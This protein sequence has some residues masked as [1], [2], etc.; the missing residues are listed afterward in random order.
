MMKE[1]TEGLL[2]LRLLQDTKCKLT[3]TMHLDIDD[4]HQE[5]SPC[6]LEFFFDSYTSADYVNALLSG[7]EAVLQALEDGNSEKVNWLLQV[8]HDCFRVIL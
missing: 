6:H 8:S 3:M 5:Q 4:S 7:N 2:L 1:V